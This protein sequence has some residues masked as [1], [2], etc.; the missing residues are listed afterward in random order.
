MFYRPARIYFITYSYK[1]KP[2]LEEAGMQ[3]ID[4]LIAREHLD[5]IKNLPTQQTHL[6]IA[7]LNVSHWIV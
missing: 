6:G 7:L 5:L 4:R 2:W 1:Y 3:A